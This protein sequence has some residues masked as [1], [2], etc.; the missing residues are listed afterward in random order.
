MNWPNRLTVLRMILSPLFFL[1]YVFPA[2]SGGGFLLSAVSMG[3]IFVIIEASDVLDGYIARRFGLVTDIGKVLDPFADVLSRI[4][5]FFCF[6][7]SGLMPAWVFL[8]IIYR[9]LAVTFLRMVLIRRGVAMAASVWGKAK[10]VTYA[11]GG[12]LGV[13]FE[14]AAR[15][16]VEKAVF[17]DILGTAALLVFVFGALSSVLSFFMYLVNARPKF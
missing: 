1:A 16:G 8:I 3:L 9:E 15:T 17:L 12:L 10:A 4:T 5:Y 13:V 14:I 7:L 11:L 2:W 6:T